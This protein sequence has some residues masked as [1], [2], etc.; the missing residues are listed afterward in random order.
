MIAIISDGKEQYVSPI[1]ALKNAGWNSEVLTFNKERTHLRRIKMW[2]PRR[3]VFIVEWEKFACK[4]SLWEG[5]DWVLEDKNLFKALRFGKAV[6][7]ENFPAFKEYSKEIILPEQFEIKNENDIQSLMD[8]S[9]SFHD[10]IPIRLEKDG[11]CTQIEFDTTWGCIITVKFEGVKESNLID[12]IGLIYD[13]EIEVKEGGFVF[14]V[15]AFDTGE[16]GGVIDFLPYEGEPYIFCDK[17]YWSI[18]IGKSACCVQ[19]KKYDSL[20]DFYIDLKSVSKNVLLKE[21]KLILH[22]KNDTLVIEPTKKGYITY[23]NGVREK[24]YTDG[25]DIYDYACM[26]L[27]RI[28]AE[29]IDEEILV[30]IK[31]QKSACF[32]HYI[33]RSLPFAVLWAAAGLILSFFCN[34]PWAVSA[35]IFIAPALLVPIYIAFAFSK[36]EKR[37]IITPTRIYCFCG[38]FINKL[39]STEQI[40]YV[41]LHLSFIKKGSGTIKIKPKGGICLSGINFAFWLIGI[42]DAEEIYNKIKKLCDCSEPE[43]GKKD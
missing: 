21:G 4:K 43:S 34:L 5:Y 41:K 10:A 6:S 3:Q 14:K 8:V 16:V 36:D 26:F 40:K 2:R 33:K 11:D 17:I 18:K 15:T 7:A 12:R 25:Q 42:N 13:S 29:D 9:M 19:C 38:K 24:G 35:I 22:H 23:L 20:Y 1:F 27:D 31:S 39:I 28:T 37:Y 30:D 32:A